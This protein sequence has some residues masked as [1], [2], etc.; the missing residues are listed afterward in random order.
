MYTSFF[1]G[2]I[3]PLLLIIISA[4]P[5]KAEYTSPTTPQAFTLCRAAREGVEDQCH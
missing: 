4:I 2:P 5:Q 1:K 3:A